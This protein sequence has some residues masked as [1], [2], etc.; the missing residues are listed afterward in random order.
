MALSLHRQHLSPSTSSEMFQPE[1]DLLRRSYQSVVEQMS[2]IFNKKLWYIML[3]QFLMKYV[4]S[5]SGLVMVAFPILTTQNAV[6]R[7]GTCLTLVPS[8]S[9]HCVRD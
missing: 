6:K 1:E 5:A 8:L 3:E 4:W 9:R 2:I 7:D